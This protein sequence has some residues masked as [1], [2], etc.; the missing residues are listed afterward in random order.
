MD[1]VGHERREDVIVGPDGSKK[2]D[3]ENNRYEAPRCTLCHGVLRVTCH[4]TQ[5]QCL[6]AVVC[7]L[8]RVTVIDSHKPRPFLPALA[9]LC[10][11][12]PGGRSRDTYLYATFIINDFDYKVLFFKQSGLTLY[13]YNY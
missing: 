1:R 9:A 6:R 5:M 2:S 7:P 8:T 13:V 4:K 10:F 11:Q 3:D 12:P